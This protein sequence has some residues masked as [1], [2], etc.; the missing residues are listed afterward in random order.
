MKYVLQISVVGFV[1]ALL[2]FFGC[3]D[4]ESTGVSNHPPEIQ[5]AS[6]SSDSV[7]TGELDTLIVS[8]SDPDGDSATH[9]WRADSGRVFHANRD[10]A[11]WSA[12]ATAG[13]YDLRVVV[14]DGRDS[15][16]AT[17][18]VQVGEYTPA[19]T[20]FYAGAQ[21]CNNEC[22]TFILDWWET[23]AH[24]DAYNALLTR[25]RGTDPQC[26]VCHTVGYDTQTNN[27]GFD[28]LMI[29][30]LA[31]VQCE[32]CHGPGSIHASAPDSLREPLES[33]LASQFCGGCHN[34]QHHPYLTE[35]QASAH[36][37]SD[38]ASGGQAQS[39]PGCTGCHTAE[40]FLASL[41]YDY[42][43]P[44]D[45]QPLV[46]L[47]CH[48]PHRAS[49]VGQLRRPTGVGETG[50]CESCHL[51]DAEAPDTISYDTPIHVQYA[52]FTGTG[53]HEYDDTTFESSQHT[54]LF[55]V[56]ACL[57]CHFYRAEND[58]ASSHDFQP[59]LASCAVVG[60][61]S[62]ATD[63]NIDA[64]QDSINTLLTNLYNEL[65]AYADVADTSGAFWYAKFNY[66]FVTNDGSK[67]VHNYKYAKQLLTESIEE[68]EP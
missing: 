36:S 15:A 3:T 34:T 28:E 49:Y 19:E 68:F 61:H 14:S 41:H 31:A 51:R 30:R 37:V 23:T 43:L 50:L 1:V 35:W 17:V 58:T 26:L 8:Y 18:S 29:D 11:F 55:E 56:E 65:D 25:G 9:I 10:T 59:K 6:V 38:Q 48:H 47:A 20:L 42:T 60:C 44:G 45:P 2:L 5:S 64:K 40:G 46:C 24:A 67:G 7:G 12:P 16:V 52:L 4:E 27:G 54:T 22:H 66:D 39:D 63:F 33:P 21:S 53:G 57:S 62:G 32:N 13:L